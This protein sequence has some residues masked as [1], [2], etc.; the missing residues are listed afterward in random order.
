MKATPMKPQQTEE[1][2]KIGTAL[3]FIRIT[4]AVPIFFTNFRGKVT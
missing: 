1:I 4:G 2:K 3:I